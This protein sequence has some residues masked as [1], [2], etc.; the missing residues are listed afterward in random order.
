MAQK[1]S[2]FGDTG[3]F[4]AL[5]D[6]LPVS[7]VPSKNRTMMAM[8]VMAYPL[9]VS[10]PSEFTINLNIKNPPLVCM[11]AGGALSYRYQASFRRH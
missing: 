11:Y 3:F 4:S 8:I 6:F 10:E 7:A 5:S 9:V 1:A 2:F